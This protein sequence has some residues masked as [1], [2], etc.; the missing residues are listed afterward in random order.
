MMNVVIRFQNAMVVVFD[1]SGE[2]IPEYQGQYEEVKEGILRDA[3]Q[4][5][6]FTHGFTNLGELRRVSRDEW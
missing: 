5:V 3:P 4:E 6:V 2:Q 1:R